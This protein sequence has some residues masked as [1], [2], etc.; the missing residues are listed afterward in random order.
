M[1]A[2]CGAEM[3]GV[4]VCPRLAVRQMG[5]HELRPMDRVLRGQHIGSH[6]AVGGTDR[7]HDGTE[8]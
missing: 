6:R 2:A 1:N 3:P 7:Q 5:V 4:R 8:V